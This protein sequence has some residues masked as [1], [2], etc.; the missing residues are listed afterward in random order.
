[1]GIRYGYAR[2]STDDEKQD[3]DRQIRE[4]IEKGCKRE[5]I[6]FEYISGAKTKRP[7]YKKLLAIVNEGDTIVSIAVSRLA[8]STKQICELLEIAKEKKLRIE[9]GSL[10]IDCTDKGKT[11]PTTVAMLQISAVFAELEREITREAVKSGMRNAKAKGKVLGRKPITVNDIPKS[12]LRGYEI[13]VKSK[14]RVSDLARL[15]GCSRTTC[16]KYI[17]LLEESQN[18]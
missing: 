7:E 13:Y 6:Y 9:A 15:C 1:M 11:D 18:E 14:M 17:K 16:Y 5:H 8:R 3:V 4:L 10:I 12:F 2:C